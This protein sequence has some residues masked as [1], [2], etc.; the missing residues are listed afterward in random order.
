MKKLILSIALL[1]STVIAFAGAPSTNVSAEKNIGAIIKSQIRFP[2]FLIEQEGEHTAVVFFKVT[3]HGTI[4][5]QDIQCDDRNLKADL[6]DQAENIRISPIGLDSHDT[7]KV[8]IR[9]ETI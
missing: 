4:K 1:T 3:E 5:V 9:F 2:E 7:Y 8:V 6:L